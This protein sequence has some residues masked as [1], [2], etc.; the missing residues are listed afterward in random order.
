[1]VYKVLSLVM[2]ALV[3]LSGCATAPA[4]TPTT[5]AKATATTAKPAASDPTKQT[6][7][8][9]KPAAKPASGPSGTLVSAISSFAEEAWDPVIATLGDSNPLVP[10]IFEWTITPNA[11]GELVAGLAESWSLSADGKT[12]TYKI[13]KGI[14]F[15]NGDEM[16]AED[17]KF[18]VERYMK[19]ESKN[20]WAP[21]YRKTIDRIEIPDPY[22]MVIHAKI[23]D[24]PFAIT[25]FGM[26]VVPKKYIEE[27]GEKYFQENPVGTGPWKFVKRDPGSSIEYEAV[28]NHWRIT[29]AFQKL[30]IKLVPEESTR[31]AMLKRGEVDVIEISLDSI[32]EMKSAGFELRYGINPNQVG[33][34]FPATWMDTGQPVMDVRVRKALSL[35]INREEMSQTFFKGFA[36]P[37]I[38]RSMSPHTWGFD[39]SWKPDPYDPQK[40][41]ELLA[42]AGYPSKFKDPVVTVWARKV[43]GA[44]WLDKWS[45]LMAGYW[46]AVGVKTKVTPI[47]NAALSNMARGVPPDQKVWG[48]AVPGTLGNGPHMV[49]HIYN[50][51]GKTGAGPLLQDDEMED[52]YMKVFNEVDENKR[53]EIYRKAMVLGREKAVALPAVDVKLVYA[54]SNKVGDWTGYAVA[55]GRQYESIQHK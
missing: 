12:W 44:G 25:G 9:S 41:K 8:E 27:K 31:M 26:F 45:E 42:E 6:T 28:P 34:G 40:A 49:Y 21:M 52:L 18:S 22:T 38:I 19:P 15:H 39:P 53:I 10:Q 46:E 37:S 47:D 23:V 30:I 20:P 13:R 54:V 14:K 48:T 5:A 36:T 24:A 32:D 50:Q 29:P 3:I 35:A 7:Q 4:A 11:K 1:M 16:T 2:A 33:M 55:L 51:Y 17:V 43:M